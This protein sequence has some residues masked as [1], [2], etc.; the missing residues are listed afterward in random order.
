MSDQALR[1]RPRQSIAEAIPMFKRR[2]FWRRLERRMGGAP[3]WRSPRGVKLLLVFCLT[4]PVL[5]LFPLLTSDR[6]VFA[7]FLLIVVP[8]GT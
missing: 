8:C 5:I 4:G 7:G 2:A 6:D 3:P 1:I